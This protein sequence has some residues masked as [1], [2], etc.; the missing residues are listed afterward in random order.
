MRNS[1]VLLLTLT[2]LVLLWCRCCDSTPLAYTLTSAEQSGDDES[3][4]P[5]FSAHT[6]LSTIS[7]STISISTPKTSNGTR[8]PVKPF[9]LQLI[10]DFLRENM[11]LIVVVA[12]LLAVIIFIA[13][14]ASILRHKRKGNAYYPSSF[15]AK[16]YVDEKDMSG[17]GRSFNEIPAKPP[18]SQQEEQV[19]STK[20]L[21]ADI[22]AAA[23]NLRSPSKAPLCE[24]EP[25]PTEQKPAAEQKPQ[26]APRA[27][28]EP[29]SEPH[30]TS[31]PEPS[32]QPL[33]P[34]PQQPPSQP[35]IPVNTEPEQSP[36]QPQ[37]C[38]NQ[39]VDSTPPKPKEEPPAPTQALNQNDA[40][41]SPANQTAQET[42]KPAPQEMQDTPPADQQPAVAPSDQT[43]STE[44]LTPQTICGET[45]AF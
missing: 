14:C 45:T 21:Q 22:K 24:Q 31:P 29:A 23:Q 41:A 35:Q 4:S 11:L 33:D 27:S 15:P 18:S 36:N 7:I 37:D 39:T 5:T 25:K 9:N 40:Q 1:L 38:S 6:T 34:A 3:E 17:G 13:C 30:S 43:Q 2:S 16:K 32:S 20:Q 12:S 8:V 10:V 19:D 42:V 28:Q 44:A 26:Q